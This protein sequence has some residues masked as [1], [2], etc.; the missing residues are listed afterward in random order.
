MFGLDVYSPRWSCIN[1]SAGR[2]VQDLPGPKTPVLGLLLEVCIFLDV[3][4]H[5]DNSEMSVASI[6]VSYTGS[7][8]ASYFGSHFFPQRCHCI[9][10]AS[11]MSQPCKKPHFPPILDM[12]SL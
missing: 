10:P 8:E 7:L 6:R 1:V 9:L 5:P 4:R 3:H 2:A 12:S 11:I